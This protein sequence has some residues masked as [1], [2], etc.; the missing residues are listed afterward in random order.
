MDEK[1]L[2]EQQIFND[3][4]KYQ[5][6]MNLPY[7]VS[8]RHLPMAQID[9]AAQFAPFSALDRFNS[10]IKEKTKKKKKIILTF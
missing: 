7:H 6:I 5:D 8:K 10:L 3:T 2:I 4:S 9:R 1:K